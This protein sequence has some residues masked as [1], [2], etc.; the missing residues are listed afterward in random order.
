MVSVV[1]GVGPTQATSK[2]KEAEMK[3]KHNLTQPPP[4]L[5]TEEKM[6]LSTRYRLESSDF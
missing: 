4:I 5:L 1:E 6:L 3:E 2:T